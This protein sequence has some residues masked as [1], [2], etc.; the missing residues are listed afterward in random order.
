MTDVRQ[1]GLNDTAK[2][3]GI[4]RRTVERRLASG[5]LTGQKI[6]GLWQVD[7]PI[8]ATATPQRHATTNSDALLLKIDALTRERDSLLA[9]KQY[10]QDALAASLTGQKQIA[11]TVERGR[12][13]FWKFWGGSTS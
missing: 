4:S 10:L 9:D 3:L 11:S 13:S 5:K 8:T 7:V 1:M 2:A 6:D 12:R